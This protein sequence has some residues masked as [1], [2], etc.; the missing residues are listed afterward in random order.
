MLRMLLNV[1]SSLVGTN[2]H[3]TLPVLAV[4]PP[5][6]IVTLHEFQFT[7][8]TPE[9]WKRRKVPNVGS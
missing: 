8:L 6:N 9:K 7:C 1:G 2:V 3:L 5:N 4:P